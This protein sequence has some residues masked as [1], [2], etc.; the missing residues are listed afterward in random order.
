[1][2]VRYLVC[3]ESVLACEICCQELINM[4]RWEIVCIVCVNT[5]ILE[6]KMYF[7]N[8]M[9]LKFKICGCFSSSYNVKSL[10]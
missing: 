1:M 7:A 6:R 2:N 4:M 9:F 5:A 8:Q 3:N 10:V